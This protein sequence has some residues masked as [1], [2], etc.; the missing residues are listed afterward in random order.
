MEFYLSK[1]FPD[2]S[3][4]LTL[5]PLNLLYC[6]VPR[7]LLTSLLQYMST[8]FHLV[9]AFLCQRGGAFSSWITTTMLI[10]VLTSLPTM[11]TQEIICCISGWPSQGTMN[12]DLA[13]RAEIIKSWPGA[14]GFPEVLL[15]ESLCRTAELGESQDVTCAGWVRWQLKD[16]LHNK[17]GTSI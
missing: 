1:V 8:V 10:S 11:D 6:K 17:P 5:T 16:D 3:S 4:T 12:S 2:F 7:V 13:C 9:T 14:L 15:N